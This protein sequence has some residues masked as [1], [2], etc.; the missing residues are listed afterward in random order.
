[1]VLPLLEGKFGNIFAP[2]VKPYQLL[3]SIEKRLNLRDEGVVVDETTAKRVDELQQR[4]QEAAIQTQQ[5]LTAAE[6]A[7]TQAKALSEDAKAMM[8]EAK[9]HEHRGK[10]ELALAKAETEM[11]TPPEMPGGGMP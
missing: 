11:Q 6:A 3:R 1:V 2:Y 10:G 7:L 4:Q 9:A 8:N 5:A